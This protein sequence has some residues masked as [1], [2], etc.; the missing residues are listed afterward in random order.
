MHFHLP[1]KAIVPERS[2]PTAAPAVVNDYIIIT[3]LIY[4]SSSHPYFLPYAADAEFHDPIIYPNYIVPTL[5]VNN[6]D[7]R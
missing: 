2:A 7:M 1:I 4:S 6:K 3:L 5:I